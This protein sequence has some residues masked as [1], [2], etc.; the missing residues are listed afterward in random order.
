MPTITFATGNPGKLGEAQ[1]VLE[2][3][4]YDVA[5][6]DAG[7]P[8]IQADTLEDVSRYALGLLADELEPPFMLED[9][10]LSVDALEGFPGVYSSYVFATLGNA[11]ILSLLEGI[12]DGERTARFRAVLGYHDGTRPR[13]FEGVVEGTITREERGERGFGFDPIFVPEGRKRTF[14]EMPADEKSGISHRGQALEALVAHLEE[15]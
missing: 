1:E 12:P 8:E 3:L 10:G 6:F 15:A 11:G 5:Q 4:G 9:A 2:P 7:Y 13:L 14:A